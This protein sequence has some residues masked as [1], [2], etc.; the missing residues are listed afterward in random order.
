MKLTA[1]PQEKAVWRGVSTGEWEPGVREHVELCPACAEVEL[2]T[3]GLATLARDATGQENL[4][5]PQQIWWRAHW[6][7]SQSAG[8]RA[9]RPIIL[10]QRFAVGGAALGIAA[11]AISNWPWLEQWLPAWTGELTLLGVAVPALAVGSLALLVGGIGTL[12]ALR[13]VLGEE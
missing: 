9:T 3:R 5:S 12:L 1:C 7:E 11:F 8:E 10:Y 6:L 4:P 13:A 2:G